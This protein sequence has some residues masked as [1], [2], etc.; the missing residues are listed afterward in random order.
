VGKN[1]R[2]VVEVNEDLHNE[3]RKLALLNNLK[4]Y[5]LTNAIIEDW[6]K[7]QDRAKTLLK[8]LQL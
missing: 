8:R 5:E 7:D 2:V 4:I 1:R 3:I 6:L